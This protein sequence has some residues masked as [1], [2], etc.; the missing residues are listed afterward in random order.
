MK[1][2]ARL[3]DV[4]QL[5]PW[6]WVPSSQTTEAYRSAREQAARRVCQWRAARGARP[7]LLRRVAAWL[8]WRAR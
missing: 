1:T 2:Q 6:R 5:S 4:A 7:G 8:G 3:H